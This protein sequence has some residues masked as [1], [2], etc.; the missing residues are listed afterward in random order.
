MSQKKQ[1]IESLF[2]NGG[3]KGPC[4]NEIPDCA[5]QLQK[6]SGKGALDLVVLS[7]RTLFAIDM[8]ID[9]LMVVEMDWDQQGPWPKPFFF[10]I[11]SIYIN[12]NFGLKLNIL[13]LFPPKENY[14]W[15]HKAPQKITKQMSNP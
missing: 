9:R 1:W 10:L 7:I 2:S 13:G 11:N 6:W 3:F 14:K 15:A 4:L 5:Y 12:L 8:L